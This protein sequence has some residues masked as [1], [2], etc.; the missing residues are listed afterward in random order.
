MTTENK[1][2]LVVGFALILFVGILVSD[3][4]SI[5]RSQE[6]ANLVPAIET[7]E[8]PVLRDP[9]LLDFGDAPR[10]RSA[11]RP[12]QL[13]T[14]RQLPDDPMQ[15]DGAMRPADDGAADLDRLV[16]PISRSSLPPAVTP[17]RDPAAAAAAR[18][19]AAD[20]VHHVRESETM[21]A[22]AEAYYGDRTL[23]VALA[24]YN[25]LADPDHVTVGRRLRIPSAEALGGRGPGTP[26]A[27]ADVANEAAPAS[28]PSG[29]RTYTV[30]R[31]DVLSVIAQKEMGSARHWKVLYEHNLDV[32]DDPDHVEAGVA[33]VI[34]PAPR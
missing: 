29:R 10:R 17:G 33:L 32:I 14:P 13:V 2:A 11:V 4:F 8:D 9:D 1:L 28:S 16:L 26:A 6:A 27:A 18:R 25:E 21:S 19:D 30:Q 3:H 22:I 31:G 5:A 12:V 15:A 20:R 24:A 7:F 23:A 34:P